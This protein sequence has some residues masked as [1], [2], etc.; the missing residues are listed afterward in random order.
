MTDIARR[1]A[2]AL[3]ALSVL[4]VAVAIPLDLTAQFVARPETELGWNALWDG[5][6]VSAPPPPLVGLLLGIWL[7]TRSDRARLIGLWV[8][9]LTG[10][11][12]TIGHV[13]EYSH[14]V[15][16][17][18]TDR[19]VFL[20]FNVVGLALCLLLVGSALSAAVRRAAPVPAT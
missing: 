13:G 15:P 5:S 20:A 6:A 9:V 12:V 19:A 1:A 18:G 2:L 8:L 3:L 7:T 10:I 11:V 16:F 14:G 4:G 17:A